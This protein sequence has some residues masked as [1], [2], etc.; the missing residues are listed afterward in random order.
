MSGGKD[1]EA[2]LVV[3][4]EILVLKYIVSVVAALG[5]TK[6]FKALSAEEARSILEVENVSL[7]ISD[8]AL[9]DGDG[10][11]ILREAIRKNRDVGGVLISGF[12][13]GLYLPSELQGRVQLLDKPFTADD[14]SQLLA[15]F[16]ERPARSTGAN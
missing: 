6:V 8:V 4:D 2:V 13:S 9:P 7:I 12:G 14:I 10:R 16:F 1:L 3:D 15:E 5:Y 11:Q